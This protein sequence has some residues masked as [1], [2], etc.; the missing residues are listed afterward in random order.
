MA[1][2]DWVDE[3]LSN[4]T[5]TEFFEEENNL[6]LLQLSSDT[7]IPTVT[8]DGKVSWGKVA[9]VTR[10]DPGKMLYE[11]KTLGGRSVIVPESKSLLVWRSETKTFEKMDTPSVRPGNCMP[12]TMQLREPPIISY[13][14]PLS[15]YLPKTSYIY[16]TDF[17]MAEVAVN[18]AMLEREQIPSGW[19]A[20]ANGKGFTL[21]YESKARFVRTLTR[22][23]TDN[24]LP[25]Y[26]YPFTTN[27]DH[28]RI[29]ESFTLDSDNGRFLGLFLAEGNVDVKSGYIAITN[30]SP[31][32][33]QFVHDWFENQRVRSSEDVK[34]NAIGGVTTTVRGYSTILAKFFD[35][36]V[37]HGAANKRVPGEAFAAP[38]SFIVGLLDGYFSGDGTVST[39]SVEA[40]SASKEL[41]EGM[42]MLCSRIGIFAKVFESQLTSNN[43]GTENILPTYRISIRAQWASAFANAVTLI[44]DAKN[45]K[46]INLKASLEHRN[47]PFQNDVVLD[48]IV[49]IN[50][51]SVDTYPKLYDLT[52]PETFT[53][54]LANGLHVYDTADTG[55]MQR[56]LIKL[57]EDIGVM[58]DYTVRTCDRK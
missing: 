33:T 31:H 28:A 50:P 11:I 20:N 17:Q 47:F 18:D 56:R 36:L 46:L 32:I 26:V 10:H 1:I 40:G 51:V 14:I 6:E 9:A 25:G 52:V 29:S 12:V 13:T 22:S 41:I 3:H 58:Y 2:G 42:S 23:K 39:N 21:P 54:G 38:T 30:N 43:L 45:T 49:E 16:G 4:S 44:D 55:Y 5:T 8:P 24:I 19:W 48:E 34:L 7:Y 53:F 27:R 37:G 57:I 15:N 35:L